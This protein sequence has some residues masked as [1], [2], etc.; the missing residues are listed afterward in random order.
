MGKSVGDWF[1]KHIDHWKGRRQDKKEREAFCAASEAN[2]LK[3]ERED[4]EVAANKDF[5]YGQLAS[6]VG[7]YIKSAPAKT[8]NALKSWFSGGDD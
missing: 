7:D 1:G 4:A 5:V 2:R 8:W 3:C 6:N